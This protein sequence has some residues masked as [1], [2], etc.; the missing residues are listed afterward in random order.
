[1]ALKFNP[2]TGALENYTPTLEIAPESNGLE[3]Q[4]NVL[5]V[6]LASEESPGVLSTED[7]VKFNNLKNYEYFYEDIILTSQQIA[8]RKITLSRIPA[9]PEALLFVP[10]G[11]VA[12]IYGV[13]YT[14]VGNDVSWAGLGLDGFLEEGEG[15]RITY[16]SE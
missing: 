11:G 16:Q 15:V 12:Q 9:F 2:I 8:D 1:M 5:S 14:I 3:L 6:N 13:D 4:N 7:Y 10:V